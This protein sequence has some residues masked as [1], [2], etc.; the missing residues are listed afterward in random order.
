M[1]TI[2]DAPHGARVTVINDDIVQLKFLENLLSR[3]GFDVFA[4]P[5]AEAALDW[6]TAQN[7]S[8]DLIIT[9][10]HM[11]GIDGSRFCR[12]LRSSRY[13][14]FNKTPILMVSAISALGELQQICAASGADAFLALPMDRSLFIGRVRAML[15]PEN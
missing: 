10:L 15:T 4:F 6:L 12:L 7:G 13:A 8:P 9:D 11:P 1:K 3:E 2:H 14:A 5:S